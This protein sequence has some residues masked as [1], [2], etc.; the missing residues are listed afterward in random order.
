MALTGVNFAEEREY[1]SPKDPDKENPT[2]FKLGLLDPF[3]RSYIEEQTTR[4]ELGS[5]GPDA[6]AGVGFSQIKNDI[7]TVRLGLVG[8]ENYLHPETGKPVEFRSTSRNIGRKM[9]TMVSEQVVSL[10]PTDLLHELAEEIRRDN[11]MTEEES[12]N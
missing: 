2:K 10:M 5:G 8:I 3:V 12:K 7:L 9:Y 11:R 6:P 1:I 4:M